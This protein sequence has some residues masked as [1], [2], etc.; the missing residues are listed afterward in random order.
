MEQQVTAITDQDAAVFEEMRNWLRGWVNPDARD[1]FDTVAGKLAVVDAV[2]RHSEF[3]RSNA[4]L[5][6]T[7][8]L[9]FGDALSQQ[10]GMKW[11]IL[12]D[13]QGRTPALI[14]PGTSLKLFA[15]TMIQ[16]RVETGEEFDAVSLFEAFCHQVQSIAQPKRSLLGRL[17]GPR[18]R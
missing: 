6:Q 3:D 7:L 11:V 13:A 4:W 17:F 16:K 8:G 12:T 10:L 5:L 1:A 18:L 2:F 14:L 15:F 9:V